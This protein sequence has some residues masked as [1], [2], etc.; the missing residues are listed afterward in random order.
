MKIRR[1]ER[2]VKTVSARVVNGVI[3]VLAPSDISDEQLAPIVAKLRGRIEK[4][5]QKKQLDN[6]ALT[7]IAARLNR[8]Y[9]QNLLSWETLEWSTE[10]NKRYGSCTPALRTIRISH[11]L[12]SMPLFVQEYVVMHELAHLVEANHGPRFWRIVNQYSRTERARG[13]LMAVGLEDL[14][15]SAT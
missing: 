12:A 7:R 8:E 10:Q 1:S 3:E 9:F 6:T 14:D 15:D 13:Y 4:K 2:R 5:Q 11:R